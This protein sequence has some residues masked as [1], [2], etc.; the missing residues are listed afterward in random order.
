MTRMNF[1]MP[2]WRWLASPLLRPLACIRLDE[3]A[4]LQGAPVVGAL[5]SIGKFDLA[6]LVAL[7]VLVAGN[8]CL[9]GHVFVLNDWAGI[10]TDSQDPRRA[11]WTFTAKG[12]K[13]REMGVL[14]L[15]LLLVGL[16]LL[17]LLSLGAGVIGGLIAVLSALYSLPG[18]GGKGIPLFNSALHLV[19]GVLH[20]LLG[21]A[22]FAALSWQA[23]AIGGFFGLVFTA[24]HFT[25]E[26]RDHD[27]DCHNNIRT[28]A[29]AFGKRRCFLASLVLFSL[30][31]VLLATLALLGLVPHVL[32]LVAGAA[33]PLH[34][35]AALRVLRA[36]LT[37]EG[38]RGLQT[39]YRRLHAIIG[40]VM[41]A[42]IP[43]W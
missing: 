26:A 2:R 8:L 1:A 18:I 14:A 6:G 21:Y 4:V 43:P 40:I 9:V 22:A 39:F 11:A 12:A 32:T 27:G 35:L 25:H 15:V 41:L 10:A 30:A 28:N 34:L 23:V 19:G 7:A 3:V 5:C 17:G 24:G 37:F 33:L 36:G 20:F 13:A 31:Y 38:L 29:V 16:G 42:T